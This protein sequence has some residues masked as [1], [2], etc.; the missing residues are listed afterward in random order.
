KARGKEQPQR[1]ASSPIS[2]SEGCRPSV[3]DGTGPMGTRRRTKNSLDR[4]SS[5]R[6]ADL[7]VSRKLIGQQSLWLP[8]EEGQTDR[9]A[10]WATALH[11]AG[12][13]FFWRP[14]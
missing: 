10:R 14:L 6:C 3:P 4:P 12:R 13:P 11:S 9:F 5:V 8:E 1:A 2:T 7:R